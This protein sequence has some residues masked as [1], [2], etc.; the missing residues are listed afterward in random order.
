[1]SSSEI[2]SSRSSLTI[3]GDS[4]VGRALMLLLRSF[5][6]EVKF[7]PA[8]PLAQALALKGSALLLLTPTPQLT[9]KERQAFLRS[10]RDSPESATIPVLELRVL[11]EETHEDSTERD[12]SWHY[13]P[14]PCRVEELQEWIDAL[15][16]WHGGLVSIIPNP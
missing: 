8:L 1:M 2:S 13:M 6:Y 14:W 12:A 10:L 7:L 9:K 3:W 4:V 16:S 11:G 15:I 5:G